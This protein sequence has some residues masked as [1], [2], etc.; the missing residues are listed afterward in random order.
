MDAAAPN[1][2]R[3]LPVWDR[4]FLSLINDPRDLPFVHL[5]IQ[6]AAVA[7][8]GVGLF[9]VP[10]PYFWWFALGYGLVWGLGVLDRYILMLHCTAHRILFKKPY[11][12]ANQIIPWVLGPFFGE[13]P[14]GYFVHHL[15]M[16]HPENN[17]H[18]DLSSTLKYQRD[19][20]FHWLRYFT[21]F[22]FF[23]TIELPIYHGK[24]G[25]LRFG[26]RA[27]VGEVYFWSIVAASALLLSWK[28]ALVVFVIPVVLVRILMMAGNWGQH[29]FVDSS[30]PNNPYKNS[31]TCINTRYN[32]RCFND[33]Y[34]INHHVKARFHWSDHPA[35]FQANK[36]HYGEEDAIVFEGIDFFQVW[37]LLML[38]QYG[39]L[40]DRFVKLPN[41][42][43]R[44]RDEI[45]AFMKSR[46]R[47]IPRPAA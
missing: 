32:R 43:E 44:S 33:G 41:A 47:P 6:C 16:H 17:M 29:A 26:L 5:I 13:P 3:S 19:K 4:W 38:K 37:A 10:D 25:N 21:R 24:K 46:L 7:L 39:V 45:I 23:I 30:D 8:M 31:L 15:G 34:H 12:W 1:L 20:V 27:V 28:A 42:P 2:E 35:E 9:F 40:A 14:E 36:A 11:K 18:D 22:F